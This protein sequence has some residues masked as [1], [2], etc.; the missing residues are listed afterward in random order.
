MRRH[1]AGYDVVHVLQG[2]SVSFLAALAAQ[3][4]GTPAVI[5]LA[6]HNQDL[7]DKGG[8]RKFLALPKRRRRMIDREV[9]ARGVMAVDTLLAASIAPGMAARKRR[10]STTCSAGSSGTWPRS[11]MRR[12]WAW[13]SPTSSRTSTS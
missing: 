7:R 2:F 1:A 12:S 13:R 9:V 5:K 4:A 11:P 6:A 10:Q 3:E 8:W